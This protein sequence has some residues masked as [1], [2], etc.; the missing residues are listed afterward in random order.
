M[1][2]NK[3]KM[4]NKFIRMPFLNKV[5]LIYSLI[6]L[7]PILILECFVWFTSSNFVREQ[8]L[9]E[10]KGMIERNTQDLENEMEQCEKSLLY[11]SSNVMLGEFLSTDDTEY[12]KLLELSETVAP[13]VYN[14]LLST[15]NFA[16]IQIYSPENFGISKDLFKNDAEVL[17]E[18][19]YIQTASVK[20]T[21]WWYDE[22][23]FIT[24]S[25]RDPVTEENLGVIRVDLKDDMIRQCLDVFSTLPA[26]IEVEAEGRVLFRYQNNDKIS[27]IGYEET[28]SLGD[29]GIEVHYMIGAQHFS[30]FLHPRI[31]VS[32]LIV[33]ALLVSA[34]FL[35][36]RSTKYLLRHLYRV[37]DGVKAVRDE[38][39]EIEVDESSGDE[40]GELAKSI[41]RMLKKIRM[42]ID[43]MY[44][45]E[46]E[47]KGLELEV[48][49]AKINPHF[50]YNNL[51]AINWI[52][53]ENGEDRI[54]E[55]ATQMAAFYRTALNRGVNVDCLRVEVENIRAYVS[56]QLYA[57][58]DS[59]DVEYD[60]DENLMDV[61]IPIFIMQPLVENAIEHGI[62]TLRA[63]RGRIQIGISE[64]DQYI[65]IKVHDNGK[66]LYQKIGEDVMPRENFGYGV[67][68]VDKRIRLLCGS[69]CG[70]TIYADAAGTMSEIKVKREIMVLDPKS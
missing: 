10:V 14:S 32:L 24:R 11:L 17:E 56:L 37:I 38:N 69:S 20:K 40:I 26:R 62:D 19:W 66:E 13:L 44:K 48:L 27:D 25:V 21:L 41:N 33:A 68:N 45:A 9:A 6:I 55:I 60:I 16:G 39:F 2:R 3:G 15:Q 58:D 5:R 31:I 47:K 49:Q 8:Q 30:T 61:K 70:V 57:H 46:L 36:D 4:K 1:R 59:F 35:V 23:F 28:A 18:E 53:I 50:L 7:I 34:W 63:E 67:R 51:S 22:T 54:Y 42:L 65:M 64:E 43:E 29:S 12:M 52:A